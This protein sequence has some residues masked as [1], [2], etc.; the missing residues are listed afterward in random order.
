MIIFLLV[1]IEIENSKVLSGVIFSGFVLCT[2]H[3]DSTILM[4]K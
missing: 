3:I 2:I 4:N 1:Q